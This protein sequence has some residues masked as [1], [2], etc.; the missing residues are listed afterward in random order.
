LHAENINTE[1][2][3]HNLEEPAENVKEAIVEEE[4]KEAVVDNINE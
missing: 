3:E 1:N 4:H 2:V